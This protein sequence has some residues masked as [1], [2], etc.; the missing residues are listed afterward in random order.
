ML[1]HSPHP[2]AMTK[3]WQE[4]E[5]HDPRLSQWAEV[6]KAAYFSE[7]IIYGCA[8]KL[9]LFPSPPGYDVKPEPSIKIFPLAKIRR[10]LPPLSVSATSLTWALAVNPALHLPGKHGR[11]NCQICPNQRAPPLCP[12]PQMR[13]TRNTCST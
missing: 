13:P 8:Y 3:I 4:G 1:F 2:S 10:S 12:Y 6:G 5:G 7:H 11:K 9:C